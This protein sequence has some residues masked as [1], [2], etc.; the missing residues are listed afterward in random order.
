MWEK[1]VFIATAA[2]MTCLMRAAIGDIVEAGGSDVA[3]ALLDECAAIASHQ[4]FR[5]RD[6]FLERTR[7]TV[8]AK[9]S[10]LMASML[11][12]IE[13]GLPAEGDHILGDLL[14]RAARLDQRSLLRLADL[15][16]RAYEGRRTRNAIAGV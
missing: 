13:G 7:A 4:G 2:G 15:H 1:W 3:S 11:R 16:V 10:P 8:R 12:D 5:P 9:G 14:R 6:A